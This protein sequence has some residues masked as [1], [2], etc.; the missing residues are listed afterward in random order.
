MAKLTITKSEVDALIRGSYDLPSDTE[1]VIIESEGKA[2]D[3][4][5]WIFN[6]QTECVH[7]VVVGPNEL[8]DI[9]DSNG[10]ALLGLTATAWTHSWD[11]NN[12]YHIVKYRKH[13]G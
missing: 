10:N 6:R 4:N 3:I 5:G 7:P 1:I 9:V 11:V 12:V 13:R 2:T 8:I